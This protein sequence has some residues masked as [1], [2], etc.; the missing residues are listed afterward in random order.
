MAAYLAATAALGL[1]ALLY[2]R[3][4]FGAAA[5][6]GAAYNA[7]VAEAARR[8]MPAPLFWGAFGLLCLGPAAFLALHV[9]DI[10][11]GL[12]LL[13]TVYSIPIAFFG[14]GLFWL[15]AGAALLW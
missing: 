13:P 7:L 9:A 1:A 5:L 8:A 2:F 4:R 14:A 11:R 6:L 12:F 10:R 3:G 15:L